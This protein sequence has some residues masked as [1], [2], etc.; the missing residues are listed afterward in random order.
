MIS[1]I[2]LLLI[3]PCAFSQIPGLSGLL[4]LVED[5]IQQDLLGGGIPG[6]G[7]P[8]GLGSLGSFGPERSYYVRGRLLCGFVPAEGATVS[9]WDNGEATPVLY[10]ESVVDASG[11]FFVKA[12]ILNGGVWNPVNPYGYISLRINHNC[13]GQRQMTVEL[14]TSYFNQGI[15]A[16]K[17]FDLGTINLEGSKN[18]I[19]GGNLGG[20]GGGIGNGFGGAPVQF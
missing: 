8:G 16:V 14:P 10:E 12:E 20:F 6:G 9:L 4:G 19:G 18:F 5:E 7:I 13:Q 15:G 2:Y 11:N 1:L 3:L 17:V